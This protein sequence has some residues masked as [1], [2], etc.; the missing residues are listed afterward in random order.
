MLLG[1]VKAFRGKGIY[2]LRREL[3]R[4]IKKERFLQIRK[5]LPLLEEER[6]EKGNGERS[7][8]PERCT[9]AEMMGVCMVS[10]VTC[11]N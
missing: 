8:R 4:N 9:W 1:K 6:R 3:W 2:G 10:M 11:V 5:K 7:A